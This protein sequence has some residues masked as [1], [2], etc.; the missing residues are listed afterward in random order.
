MKKRIVV[1]G[2]GD[3]GL[4][5]AIRLKAC[6]EVIAI[7]CKPCFVSGQEL[8]NRLAQLEEWKDLNHYNF[9][10]FKN[11]DHIRIIHGLV[12]AVDLSEQSVTIQTIGD[13]NQNQQNKN[14]ISVK[15]HYDAL[16]IATGTTNGFWRNATLETHQQIEANMYMQAEK[17][18]KA[19]TIAVV[20]GGPTAVSA[21][22]NLKL[23]YPTKSVHLFFSRAKILAGYAKRTRKDVQNLLE[24]QGVELHS[25]H[26]AKIDGF[27]VRA[28]GTG[29]I[30]WQT[31][32][33][34]QTQTQT[35]ATTTKAS[36][37]RQPPPFSADA[38][39]WAVGVTFPNNECLPEELLDE[40]GYVEVTPQLHHPKIRNVFAIGDICSSDPNRSTA[41]NA[42]F[43]LVAKNMDLYLRGKHKRL[44]SFKAPRYRW[45]SILG[46]QPKGMRI[47][48]Q[49]G[50]IFQLKRWFTIKILFPM[51]VHKFIYKGI[52]KP[53]SDD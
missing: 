49:T 31:K 4:L 26:R 45:G 51:I 15:E 13:Q 44:A 11:L 23:V 20:G 43:V 3:S 35:T 17:F 22:S 21:A 24:L 2:L 52:R 38:I 29:D 1:I 27:D 39:L 48:S 7:S 8:G 37:I 10:R 5:T 33:Q 16:L 42:G 50:R 28:I 40:D 30:H 6:Y 9:D 14:I 47:Y 32:S 53:T 36:D 46:I 34:T 12:K 25:N 19:Q 41:R 18:R